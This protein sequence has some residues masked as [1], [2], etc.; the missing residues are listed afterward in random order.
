MG[1]SGETTAQALARIDN[2]IVK[3]PKVVLITLGG[4]T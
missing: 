1:V 2:V 4:M 3:D